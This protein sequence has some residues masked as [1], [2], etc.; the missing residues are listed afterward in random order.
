[1]PCNGYQSVDDGYH[2]DNVTVNDNRFTPSE[3]PDLF[4]L[5]HVIF[6]KFKR[7]QIQQIYKTHPKR[8]IKQ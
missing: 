8:F 5:K 4:I 3:K 1:M 7:M 2:S 6:K